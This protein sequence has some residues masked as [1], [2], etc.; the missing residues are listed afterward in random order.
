[1]AQEQRPTVITIDNY[2]EVDFEAFRQIISTE[3]WVQINYKGDLFIKNYSNTDYDLSLSVNCLQAKKTPSYL[4]EYS[5]NYRDGDYGGI[6]FISSARQDYA[7]VEFLIDGQNYQDPFSKKSNTFADF[8]TN[9]KTGK[10]LTIKVY[11]NEFNPH[12]G[13]DELALNRAI[14]FKL[15]N[16]P[17]LETK[18]TCN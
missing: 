18:V 8:S 3:G 1:M 16:A 9:L 10:I 2:E 17:L 6:D 7:K 11:D 15:G 4:I 12:T 5:H 14:D 13:K